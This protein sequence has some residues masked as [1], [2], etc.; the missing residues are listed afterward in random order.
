MDPNQVH[1]IYPP[2]ES[3]IQLYLG[4]L[5]HAT[6]T[7]VALEI[8][9]TGKFIPQEVRDG[10]D[11]NNRK[12]DLKQTGQKFIFTCALPTHFC[13]TTPA[14]PGTGYSYNAI[15]EYWTKFKVTKTFDNLFHEHRYGGVIFHISP[16]VLEKQKK[17]VSVGTNK[18]TTEH[19]HLQ[20]STNRDDYLFWAEESIPIE[21][22]SKEK[23]QMT[24][25]VHKSLWEQ[26]EILFDEEI[27]CNSTNV[28]ISFCHHL[29]RC[30]DKNTNTIVQC[31]VHEDQHLESVEEIAG[32]FFLNIL[33]SL[34]KKEIINLDPWML[35]GDEAKTQ[36]KQGVSS[37]MMKYFDGTLDPHLQQA[38]TT[39]LNEMQV[40]TNNHKNL[41]L[42]VFELCATHAK[43]C[44]LGL[45]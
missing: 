23:L 29:N 27:S 15:D 28:E 1:F 39:L 5:V 26:H 43:F 8:I 17:L 34:K 13:Q 11:P 7:N 19:S 10:W 31:K 32:W 6:H 30:L 42:E 37:L 16:K 45:V 2:A 25:Q 14:K 38:M 4:E 12:R 36:M 24:Y 18:Y 22:H 41:V 35:F 21:K 3:V 33:K 9:R 20:I 44:R 40:P